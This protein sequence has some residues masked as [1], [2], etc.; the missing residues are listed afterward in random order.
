MNI[1]TDFRNPTISE[2]KLFERLFDEEFP[3]RAELKGML[4]LMQVRTIDNLGGLKLLSTA[5]TRAPVIKRI[6][7]EAEAKDVDGVMIHV[8]LH[9]KDGQPDELEIY[10]ED[11]GQL[12]RLP[13]P[14]NFQLI[15]LPPAPDN[16]PM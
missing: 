15:I 14:E 13:A 12:K 8:L 9:T 1:K 6:P 7:V 10:R 5:K 3:G 2:M 11:G 16:C 4:P